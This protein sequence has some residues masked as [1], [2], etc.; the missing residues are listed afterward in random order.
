MHNGIRDRFFSDM[1]GQQFN[2]ILEDRQVPAI[3]KVTLV[4]IIPSDFSGGRR[5]RF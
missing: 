2:F 5:S 1:M 4:G 3:S